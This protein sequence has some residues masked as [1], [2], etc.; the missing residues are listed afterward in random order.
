MKKYLPWWLKIAV[1]IVLSRLPVNYRFWSDHG[2]FQ[3]GF[4]VDPEYAYRTFEE[5]YQ[6][7]EFSAKN[8]QFTCLELG[9]G[10][11]VSSALVAKGFNAEKCY[12]VDAGRYASEKVR[13]YLPLVQL[14]KEK[15]QAIPFNQDE[16]FQQML[17]QCQGVYLTDG[18]D[19]LRAIPD[20][21]VDFIFSQA[22]LEHVRGDV[23]LPTMHELK[24]I[25]KPTGVMSHRVDLKDHLGSALN[26]LRFSDAVW[27]SDLMSQSGFYTNRIRYSEMLELF[28]SA[29]LVAN[30]LHV[31]RWTNLP[32]AKSVLAKKF[33]K[34]DDSELLVQGFDVVLKSVN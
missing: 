24:R 22:V 16:S 33:Q 28:K 18:L 12:L 31:D 29:G 32:T 11:S 6:R 17:E 27:E 14:L 4:M 15:N 34:L 9:C 7:V 19:S 25:L 30:V 26:N 13:D 10:D 8:S 2:L 20:D 3:H 23:F 5:H 21:S 1:K